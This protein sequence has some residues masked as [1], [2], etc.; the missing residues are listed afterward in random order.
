MDSEPQV[1]RAAGDDRGSDN[2]PGKK[3][4]KVQDVRDRCGYNVRRHEVQYGEHATK[5]T[6]SLASH[7]VGRAMTATDRAHVLAAAGH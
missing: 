4:E 3:I 5:G 7:L 1:E 2:Q 6:P